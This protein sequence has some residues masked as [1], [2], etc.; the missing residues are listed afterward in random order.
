LSDNT[1]LSL[2]LD[3]TIIRW[4][5]NG[6]ILSLFSG[7]D[8]YNH[9]AVLINNSTLI[10]SSTSDKFQQW[11]L[12]TS[13]AIDIPLREN[14]SIFIRIDDDTICFAD[15]KRLNIR[16]IYERERFIRAKGFIKDIIKID[17]VNYAVCSQ[18]IAGLHI[19]I[20][21]KNF[22]T[23]TKILNIGTVLE[24]NKDN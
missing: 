5:I 22:R 13:K 2:S 24:Y 10:T 3:E 23:F 6:Q 21:N 20:F 18:S 1:F 12:K 19:Q 8:K 9:M 11:N 17:T 15:S 16:N 7:L 14:S 4:N